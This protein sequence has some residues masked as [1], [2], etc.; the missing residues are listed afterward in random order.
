M[1][2]LCPYC[3]VE[4]SPPPKKKKL[5][6]NC[7]N[8]VYV[9]ESQDL[10]TGSCFTF[11]TAIAID[12]YKDN[13]SL[14]GLTKDDYLRYERVLTARKGSKSQPISIVWEV[15]KDAARN[16]H[17]VYYSMALVLG[18]LGKDPSPALL[19]HAQGELTELKNHGYKKVEILSSDGCPSCENQKKKYPITEALQ[20]MPIPNRECSYMMFSDEFAFCRCMYLPV[21]DSDE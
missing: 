18:K 6:K 4:L 20:L 13:F 5:C 17:I 8:Y 16:D 2:V 19:R 3:S 14:R 10:L 11:E 9:R 21:L 1:R 12:A 7:G 15:L